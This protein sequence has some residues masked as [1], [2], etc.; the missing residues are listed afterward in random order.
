MK[1]ILLMITFAI[2]ASTYSE[3]S[4]AQN[5]AKSLCEYVSAD[6]KSR[7]RSFLKTNKLKIRNI[8]DDVKCNG[9]NLVAF[10][11]T[12]NA[13]KTGELML[14]KLPKSRVEDLLTTITSPELSA[15]A[16]KRING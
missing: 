7:L 2:L 15:A 8:F 1:N 16:Q 6:D 4:Q 14:A 3:K 13:L 9:Q 5:I 11:G 12:N 10:A